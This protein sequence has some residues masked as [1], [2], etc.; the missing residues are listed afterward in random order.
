MNFISLLLLLSFR[1]FMQLS[2]GNFNW[3][4]FYQD[5]SVDILL[6]NACLELPFIKSLSE[7]KY[8][9]DIHGSH[10]VDYYKYPNFLNDDQ[11]TKPFTLN[12]QDESRQL[13]RRSI[14]KS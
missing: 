6:Q 8:N 10:L 12:G 1:M 3:Q 9:H 13:G 14:L 2:R 4:D 7:C 11:G 5:F